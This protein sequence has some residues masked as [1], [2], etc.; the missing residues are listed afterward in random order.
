MS[1]GEDSS[2]AVRVSSVPSNASV[3]RGGRSLLG[4]RLDIDGLRALAII[5]VVVFHAFPT[6]MPGL[7]VW[8]SSL[9]FPAF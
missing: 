9:L 1:A 4:Y 5:P 8:T 2:L 3:T 7:S 6:A